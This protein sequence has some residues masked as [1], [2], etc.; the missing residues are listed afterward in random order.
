[1]CVC[2][3]VCVF[4]VVVPFMKLYDSSGKVCFCTLRHFVLTL[5]F[6]SL[7]K[8]KMWSQS[9]LNLGPSLTR[10]APTMRYM[11]ILSASPPLPSHTLSLH[12]TSPLTT[13][14]PHLSSHHTLTTPF[15]SCTLN[16]EV[17]HC[18]YNSIQP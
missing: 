11:Y 7:H 9:C 5:S 15:L 10:Q 6:V 17:M 18:T 16:N 2:V 1:M 3:C 8:G 4:Q 13:P 14:S 12:H